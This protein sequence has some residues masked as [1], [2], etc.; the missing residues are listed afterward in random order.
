[1]AKEDV[2]GF[3]EEL[4][5]NEGLQAKMKALQ[6]A[7]T[8]DPEDREA[9]VEAVVLP[10]ASEAGFE[11]TVDD[12]KELEAEAPEGSEVNEDELA[13]IAGGCCLFWGL[14]ICVVYGWGMGQ[15]DAWGLCIVGGLGG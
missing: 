11:F 13:A 5:R 9:M 15:G 2:R 10:V 6:D 3:L 4:S 1:M 7:Y 12:I 8:G 14:G